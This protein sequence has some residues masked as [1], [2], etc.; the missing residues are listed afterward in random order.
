M[1]VQEGNPLSLSQQEVMEL[2]RLARLA[3]SPEEA[4]ALAGELTGLLEICRE[5]VDVDVQGVAP[6]VQPGER[7][8]ELRP[9]EVRP[10]LTQEEALGNA[11]DAFDGYF[12]VPSMLAGPEGEGGGA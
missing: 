8:G 7:P 12:R 1:M 2:A 11:P 6:L 9:D 3:V 4:A 10:G 5:V